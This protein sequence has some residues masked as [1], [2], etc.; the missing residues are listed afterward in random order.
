MMGTRAGTRLAPS[1]CVENE[2]YNS[3]RPYADAMCRNVRSAVKRSI[4]R[5]ARREVVAMWDNAAQALA[6][7]FALQVQRYSLTAFRKSV[8]GLLK[9]ERVVDALKEPKLRSVISGIVR[10]NVRLIRS[11]PRQYIAKVKTAILSYNDGTLT[12]R[13][14]EDR[15]TVLTD[16]V[17]TRMRLIARDQNE[18]ATEAMMVLRMEA[19]GMHLVK[20]VHTHL[21]EKQPREYHL[22]KWDGRSGKRSGKPNGLNGYI[23]DL[24]NPPVIDKKSGERGYPAQLI[25]CKCYLVPVVK[26]P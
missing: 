21:K 14:F 11:I 12:K 4:F 3:L 25:N 5:Y 16:Q 9:N 18:K 24:S 15:M 2:Y 19:N 6:R 22:T 7:Q 20:W 1:K 17:F 13:K 10:E 8:R 26:K 23:F